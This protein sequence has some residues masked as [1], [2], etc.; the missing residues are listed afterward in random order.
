MLIKVIQNHNKAYGY[1]V[2][3]FWIE[4]VPQ[5]PFPYMTPWDPP[6]LSSLVNYVLYIYVHFPSLSVK[7]SAI[8][9][10]HVMIMIIIMIFFLSE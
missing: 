1:V 9:Y 4:T 10:V 3:C 2:Q 7:P 8:I 6:T 5:D